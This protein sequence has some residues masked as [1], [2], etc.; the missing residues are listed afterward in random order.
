M[1]TRQDRFDQNRNIS[2]TEEEM[3]EAYESQIKK[4]QMTIDTLND[5]LQN[6]SLNGNASIQNAETNFITMGK[7]PDIVKEIP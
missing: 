1:S 5:Q 4:M 7:I 6:N 3:T 2:I